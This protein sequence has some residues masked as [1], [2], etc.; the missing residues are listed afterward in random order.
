M[1]D[2][3]SAQL[4]YIYNRIQEKFD[5]P[6]DYYIATFATGNGYNVYMNILNVES[7][8]CVSTHT[9]SGTLSTGNISLI[10]S[11]YSSGYRVYFKSNVS[12]TAVI[13]GSNGLTTINMAPNTQYSLAAYNAVNG[14]VFIT[15]VE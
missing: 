3:Q 6:I 5:Q 15:L 8:E 1:T 4:E 13:K 14:E 7:A 11:G 9:G 2:E 10:N 12:A